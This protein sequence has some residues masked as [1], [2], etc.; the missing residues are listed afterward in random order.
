MNKK[1]AMCKHS[2]TSLFAFNDQLSV[3]T[4]ISCSDQSRDLETNVEVRGQDEVFQETIHVPHPLLP[5]H[6]FALFQPLH[7]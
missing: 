3:L 7:G 1:L 5:Y 2:H 6:L 4:L